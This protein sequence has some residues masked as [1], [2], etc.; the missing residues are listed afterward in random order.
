MSTQLT[1]NA[2]KKTKKKKQ[3]A[4]S[5]AMQEGEEEWLVFLFKKKGVEFPQ[6]WVKRVLPD[7]VQSMIRDPKAIMTYPVCNLRFHAR[8]P[9]VVDNANCGATWFI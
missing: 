4:F 7:G 8:F 1:S 6:K 3:L 5:V 2:K 9:S